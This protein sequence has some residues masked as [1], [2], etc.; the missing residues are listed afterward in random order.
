MIKPK[1][2]KRRFAK[3]KKPIPRAKSALEETLDL[4]LK[5]EKICFE[6]E[7]RFHPV[8]RWRFDFYIPSKKLLID[9]QGGI[10]KKGA[11]TRAGGYTNDIE[12]MNAAVLMG[13]KVLW[14]TREQ[15][16]KEYAINLIKE[17]DDDE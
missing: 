7:Y 15:I 12:K 9:C 8:R 3:A 1:P 16:F 2:L 17:F 13:Y 4:K 10:H 5:V 14:F 11:H 6:R